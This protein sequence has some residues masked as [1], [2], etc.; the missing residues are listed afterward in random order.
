MSLLEIAFTEL[1]RSNVDRRHP[2]RSMMLATHATFPEVRTVVKRDFDFDKR[3][4]TFYTDRRTPKCDQI[5]KNSKVSLLL[6]HP[7]KKL[8]LRIYATATLLSTD[9]AKH[10][11]ALNQISNS[12][13]KNDYLTKHTPG[14][15]LT[16][17]QVLFGVTL[18]LAVVELLI[19]SMDIVLLSDQG[20]Q[21]NRYT[22]HNEQWKEEML[23]P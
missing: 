5:S 17:G 3:L 19:S 7:K 14:T 11:K 23:V 2:Y 12:K 15:S 6:Y 22:F 18:H 21:R 20:H 16:D 10:K 13:S 4:I 8:Q 9:H 1:G